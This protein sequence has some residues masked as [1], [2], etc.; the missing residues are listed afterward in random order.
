MQ[1]QNAY[2]PLWRAFAV[3]VGFVAV[4][5]LFMVF[6]GYLLKAYADSLF[7]SAAPEVL[8]AIS[9]FAIAVLTA[10]FYVAL[11]KLKDDVDQD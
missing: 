8:L 9:V 6:Y 2:A 5:S 3:F 4:A 7:G 10:P 1:C 11:E